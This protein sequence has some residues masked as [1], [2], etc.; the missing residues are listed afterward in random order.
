MPRDSVQPRS[1]VWLLEDS[2]MEAAMARRA[3][4]GAYDVEVFTDGSTLIERVVGGP[5]PAVMIL[6]VQLPGMSG[7]EVCRFLRTRHDQTALPILMLTVYGHKSDLIEGLTAG[8]NDYLTKPYDALELTARVTSLV[9]VKLLHEAALHAREQREELFEREKIARHEVANL[10]EREKAARRDAEAA[11]TAKD[12]FLA[13]VSHELRTPLSSILGWT[14]LLRSGELPE[15]RR[16]AALET[17]ERNAVAQSRLIEDLL[18]MSRIISRQLTIST[19]NVELVSL[20]NSSLD[21]VKPAAEKKGIRIRADIHPD[22]AAVDGDPAR[23]QQVI[24]NLLSN[25]IKFT[26]KGGE[27]VLG[28]EPVSDQVE[29]VVADTGCGIGPEFLPHVFEPFRQGEHGSTRSHRGLGLGLAIV[30]H[31]VDLHFGNVVAESP[32]IGHGATFRVRLPRAEPQ[33]GPPVLVDAAPPARASRRLN[34]LRVVVVDDEPDALELVAEM[35][36]TAGAEVTSASSAASAL[37]LIAS[38]EPDAI[39]S[40]V[41]M[42]GE[43]GYSLL[44]KVRQL[45]DRRSKTPAVALTAFAHERDRNRAMAAGFDLHVAKPV[46]PVELVVAVAKL[47]RPN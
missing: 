40:D 17:I 11:S 16:D 34:G 8:A 24:T 42:P 12:E 36:R 21:A 30:K 18:D 3:L 38:V 2:P 5:V 20:V 29:I 25:A 7:I 26:G 28:L 39:V 9:R 1:V 43:D 37:E 45:P 22:G 47:I 10:L 6:D 14:R 27:V 44:R 19:A 31:I 46:D 33:S 35:L 15:A 32:G 4:A 23:L 41:G 13:M